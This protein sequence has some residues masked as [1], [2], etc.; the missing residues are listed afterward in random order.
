MLGVW[1]VAVDADLCG[2]QQQLQ[3]VFLRSDPIFSLRVVILL[4]LYFI[5]A[6]PGPGWNAVHAGSL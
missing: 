5:T 6:R 2:L 3:A 1:G 4:K